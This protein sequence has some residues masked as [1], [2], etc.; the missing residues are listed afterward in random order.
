[1]G[2]IFIS[3]RREDSIATTGRLRDKLV[4]VFGRNRVFVDVDDI[5]A[6][7]NFV[8]ILEGQVKSCRVLLA[9]IGP[10]WLN[11]KDA[12]GRRRLD[13]PE[14]FVAL[15]LQAA[16]NTRDITVIPVLIDG[17][18]MPS[19][20]DLPKQL[21]RLTRRNAVELDN[22]RFGTDSD[23]LVIAIKRVIGQRPPFSRSQKIALGVGC[24]SLAVALG[25]GG[26]RMLEQWRDRPVGSSTAEA[27]RPGQ[28]AA[29]ES[30]RPASNA[31]PS[32]R[33]VK[34]GP[35][36]GDWILHM[37]GNSYCAYRDSK[38]GI[39]VE[40]GNAKSGPHSGTVSE[41][42]E[43]RFKSYGA[44]GLPVRFQGQFSGGSGKGTYYVEN[45]QC[46]GTFA[47]TR[48]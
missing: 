32:E 35:F 5:P 3:Y 42:G 33:T 44:A 38:M 14:D 2:N 45:H 26:W 1:M 34:R 4:Q 29:G 43:F 23:K 19:A 6:G 21:Q 37:L 8:K 36:D 22:A 27:D 41:A 20:S 25:A 28:T 12:K 47:A 18:K 10:G 39:Q 7:G 48:Q 24:V 30:A 40:Q 13:K 15:E 16:L 31:Q 9:M 11:S 17:A 46:K